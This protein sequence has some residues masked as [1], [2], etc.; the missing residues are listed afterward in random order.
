MQSCCLNRRCVCQNMCQPGKETNHAWHT[1][2][3]QAEAVYSLSHLNKDLVRL[4]T[5]VDQGQG[6]GQGQ[7]REMIQCLFDGL[8]DARAGTGGRAG[9][10]AGVEG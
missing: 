10:R 6:L 5:G 1:S 3:V 9:A 7:G 8:G 4:W 2:P